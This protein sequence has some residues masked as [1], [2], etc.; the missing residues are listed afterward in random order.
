MQEQARPLNK[1]YQWLETVESFAVIGSVGGAIAS[2]VSQQ[3]I[4][5]SIPL[6]LSVM[7]NVVNRRLLLNSLN[8]SHQ[9]AIAS[10]LQNS[11][12]IT[13]D[14]FTPIRNQLAQLQ[15]KA[16]NL[17][18]SQD[19]FNDAI[20]QIHQENSVT[21]DKIEQ[22]KAQ[23]GAQPTPKSDFKNEPSSDIQQ[24]IHEQANINKT[25]QILKE[26]EICS[27]D[28]QLNPNAV[29]HYK[30]GLSYESIAEKQAAVADYSAAISLDSNYAEAYYQR[31][32][33]YIELG[34]K[35][36]A[37]KDLRAAAKSF[38]AQGDIEKYQQA[39]HLTKQLHDSTKL[40][41]SEPNV[42]VVKALFAT[43]SS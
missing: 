37:I 35:K 13:Q 29:A 23:F 2:V 21:Q 30:R 15:E 31:G 10:T 39:K 7:L 1:Q 36:A 16:V 20:A 14:K 8:Q 18:R 5:A 17:G 38:F 9:S 40:Q 22:I 4:F 26:I 11:N 34:N 32:L 42:G 24:L 12:F 3:V 41:A 28:V 25:L 27:Q 19:N 6:S 33:A 43:A